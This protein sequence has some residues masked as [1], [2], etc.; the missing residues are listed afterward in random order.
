MYVILIFS[1]FL[2][3]PFY[4]SYN[5]TISYITKYIISMLIFTII[6]DISSIDFFNIFVFNEFFIINSYT[7]IYRT[8]INFVF[9]YIIIGIPLYYIKYF[10]YEFFILYIFCIIGVV[11]IICTN[12]YFGIYVFIELQSF[13]IY[14]FCSIVIKN[15][16]TIMASIQY[17]F[18][19]SFASIIILLGIALLYY[20]IGNT[21]MI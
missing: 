21:S 18:I 20:S 4:N 9:I 12:D 10:N 5:I 13:V 6:L 15:K 19:G 1:L 17:F 3:I 2:T 16:Y 11:G 7:F 14:L 8:F